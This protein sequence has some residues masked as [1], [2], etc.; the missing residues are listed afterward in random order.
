MFQIDPGDENFSC[1]FILI[2][3]FISEMIDCHIP[4]FY[5]E[6]KEAQVKQ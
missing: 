5:D 2:W 6:E 1:V 3:Y 4:C